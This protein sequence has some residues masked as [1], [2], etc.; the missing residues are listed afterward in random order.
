MAGLSVAGEAFGVLGPSVGV[1]LDG[2]TIVWL[3][4]GCVPMIGLAVTGATSGLLGKSE[5]VTLDGVTIGRPAVEVA[6]KV[7]YAATGLPFEETILG[8]LGATP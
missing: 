3:S 7:G 5:G 1:T 4:I 8:L 2:A 6:T